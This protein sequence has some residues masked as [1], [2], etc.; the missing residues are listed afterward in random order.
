MGIVQSLRIISNDKNRV[1]CSEPFWACL[2]HT[3]RPQIKARSFYSTFSENG[4]VI[5]R[6]SKKYKYRIM[7]EYLKYLNV[8]YF[9]ISAN[10]TTPMR[11]TKWPTTQRIK[12]FLLLTFDENNINNPKCKPNRE[13]IKPFLI[14]DYT[15]IL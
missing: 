13:R 11:L 12:L 8:N 9:Q 14:S 4:K 1:L 6:N 15:D 2:N 5:Y 7:T 3:N 10:Y